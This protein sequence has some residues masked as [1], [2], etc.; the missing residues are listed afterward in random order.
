M[1]KEGGG[2]WKRKRERGRR[3]WDGGEGREQMGISIHFLLTYVNTDVLR[4]LYVLVLIH[5]GG[6]CFIQAAMF[7]AIFRLH[8]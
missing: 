5:N 7:N 8:T 2:G 3:M 6:C 4:L 1:V